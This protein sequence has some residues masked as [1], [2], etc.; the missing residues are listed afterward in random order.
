MVRRSLLV[1]MIVLTTVLVGASWTPLSGLSMALAE[2]R[3]PLGLV[4]A[5]AMFYQSLSQLDLMQTVRT[6]P[7]K[8]R[9]SAIR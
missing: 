1:Q 8:P 9:R 3:L 4:L 5:F 6:R 2:V 7:T